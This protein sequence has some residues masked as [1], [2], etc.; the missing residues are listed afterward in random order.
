MICRIL[1]FVVPVLQLDLFF[2]FGQNEF[3]VNFW[4]KW[5][6]SPK[7]DLTLALNFLSD[8]RQIQHNTSQN[9][10]KSQNFLSNI[11]IKNPLTKTYTAFDILLDKNNVITI[12]LQLRIIFKNKLITLDI[13]LQ[14]TLH[15]TWMTKK[16]V[17]KFYFC[18]IPGKII[19]FWSF[20][21][22]HSFNPYQ[23]Y[24]RHRTSLIKVIYLD[25]MYDEI[26][27]SKNLIIIIT[28][29]WKKNAS[30]VVDKQHFVSRSL[31]SCFG[32]CHTF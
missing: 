7:K 17:I 2:I 19:K 29:K 25:L 1:F 3:F 5:I 30:L 32:F 10:L 20:F 21:W 15:F 26:V 14:V 18:Q 9:A 27:L 28:F 22:V 31:L 8:G 24:V 16:I 4:S 12:E 13:N 6:F 23:F 11:W